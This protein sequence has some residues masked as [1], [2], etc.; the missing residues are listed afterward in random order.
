M[1]VMMAVLCAGCGAAATQ[2]TT[3]VALPNPMEEVTAQVLMDRLGFEFKVPQGAENVKYF[4][5]DKEMAEMQFTFN[6]VNCIA[7]I[8][9]TAEYEDIS[10]MYY[11]WTSKEKG[12]VGYCDADI[13]RYQGKDITVDA[14]L[15]FDVAPGVMYSVTGDGQDLDGFD[16]QAIAEQTYVPTQGDAG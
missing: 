15:W 7:R 12:K 16:I 2:E 6:G 14:C 10:G 3:E 1:A 11:E 13:M 5:I 4:I 9:P 8:K